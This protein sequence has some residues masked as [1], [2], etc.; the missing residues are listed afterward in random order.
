MYDTGFNIQFI[1]CFSQCLE[2]TF[3]WILAVFL[4]TYLSNFVYILSE[5]PSFSSN[6]GSLRFMEIPL[7]LQNPFLFRNFPPFFKEL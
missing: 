4:L 7:A 2:N 1:F 3:L 6:P 5:F